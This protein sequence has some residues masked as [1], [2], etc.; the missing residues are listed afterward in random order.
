MRHRSLADRSKRSRGIN[1][2]ESRNTHR[3]SLT[4]PDEEEQQRDAGPGQNGGADF[5]GVTFQAVADDGDDVVEDERLWLCVCVCGRL[6]SVVR[7]VKQ[8]P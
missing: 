2:S 3:Q 8:V 6:V 5:G 4:V 1:R 7:R